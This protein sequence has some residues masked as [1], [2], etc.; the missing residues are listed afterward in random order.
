M[1]SPR[2]AERWDD[3]DSFLEM[4]P[5]AFLAMTPIPVDLFEGE[6]EAYVLL[7]VIDEPGA[8][9]AVFSDGSYT[10]WTPPDAVI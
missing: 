7:P 2:P 10:R 3:R 4:S 1:Q 9:V 5:F 8:H 6:T